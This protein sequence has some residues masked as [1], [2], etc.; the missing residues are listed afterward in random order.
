MYLPPHF[1]ESD[2]PILHRLIEAHPLGTWILR[3]GDNLEI[4]HI[5]FLIDTAGSKNGALLGHIAR[6]N[7]A[8]KNGNAQS[9]I[10][11]TGEHGYVS[12][13]S[14]PSKQEH[15]RV[16]P[17]WNYAVVH[18][19]GVAEFIEDRRSLLELITRLTDEHEKANASPWRVADTP[20]DY[21]D[22]MLGAIVGVRIRI[23]RLEGKF[24]LSQNRSETDRLGVVAGLRLSTDAGDNA[25]ATFMSEHRN[26]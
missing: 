18:A 3:D 13:S 1:K 2:L 11:F 24:K 15:H 4:N 19:H 22:K 26:P 16:V 5:P 21:I 12:P 6:A 9:T 8:W 23:E 17:T 7:P 10:I 20:A 14:Y 25:L